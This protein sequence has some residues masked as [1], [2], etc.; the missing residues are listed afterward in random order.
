MAHHEHPRGIPAQ[1]LGVGPCPGDRAC[2]VVH[3]IGKRVP[4][5]FAI[6]GHQDQ[7]ARAGESLADEAV[8]LAIPIPP[9]SAVNEH[10]YRR[11]GRSGR[12]DGSM[13]VQ[14]QAVRLVVKLTA[15]LVVV[16]PQVDGAVIRAAAA[17]EGQAG[18]QG[19]QQ[20]H[21]RAEV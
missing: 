4:G 13:H 3:E 21:G 12:G 19:N 10:H 14:G 5:R 15:D 16:D 18:Q 11:L 1:P 20:S 2:G 6:V 7:G 17:P 9:A 8:T